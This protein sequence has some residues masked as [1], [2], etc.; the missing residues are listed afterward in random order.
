[1]VPPSQTVVP[2]VTSYTHRSIMSSNQQI[3]IGPGPSRPTPTDQTFHHCLMQLL[4]CYPMGGTRSA[5]PLC[6]AYSDLI[7][8]FAYSTKLTMCHR[9]PEGVGEGHTPTQPLH[10]L[11]HHLRVEQ[12]A[13]LLY[14]DCRTV[15][16]WLPHLHIRS[17]ESSTAMLPSPLSS[18]ATQGAHSATVC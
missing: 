9:A 12:C 3:H 4:V 10:T 16:F 6:A 14:L 2:S 18:G 17:T 1:M 7:P 8:Q 5:P 13:V 15:Q 11:G